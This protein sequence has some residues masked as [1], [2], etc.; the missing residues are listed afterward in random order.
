MSQALKSLVKREIISYKSYFRKED[1]T[2]YARSRF[3]N[4]VKPLT[5]EQVRRLLTLVN[6]RL[7]EIFSDLD[8]EA[9][10]TALKVLGGDEAL[11]RR[12]VK[13][14]RFNL[15][16][17]QKFQMSRKRIRKLIAKRVQEAY[18]NDVK[19]GTGKA[20]LDVAQETWERTAEFSKFIAYLVADAWNFKTLD[21]IE[22]GS[23]TGMFEIYL[24]ENH[25]HED[26]CNLYA[27]I[28]TL[29][30]DVDLPPYHPYCVCSVRDVTDPATRPSKKTTV[31]KS[32]LTPAQKNA[33]KLQAL[34]NEY[35][36]WYGHTFDFSGMDYGVAKE[37]AEHYD[38]L[39][40]EYPNTAARLRYIGTYQNK[41]KDDYGHRLD[42][43]TIA[44]AT[45]DGK[46]IA[47]NHRYFSDRA[48]IEGAKTESLQSNWSVQDGSITTSLTHEFGH[49]LDNYAQHLPESIPV[50]DYTM[51]SGVGEYWHIRSLHY[52]IYENAPEDDSLSRY[53]RTRSRWNINY[54]FAE[55]RAESI[56][57]AWHRSEDKRTEFD[58]AVE[59]F[60]TASEEW[61]PEWVDREDY[62]YFEDAEDKDEAIKSIVATYKDFGLDIAIDAEKKVYV[63]RNGLI[64]LMTEGGEIDRLVYAPNY[65]S[66][67]S[68]QHILDLFD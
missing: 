57:A 16:F 11:M 43:D 23:Q 32:I 54:P 6:A 8:A 30:D 42:T 34:E 28:Y 50:A 17:S 67:S 18:S 49:Q 66:Q 21:K 35:E 13:R 56:S 51:E 15:T 22:D 2:S 68:F 48:T 47:F 53:A 46:R 41:D 39:A 52:S 27:G 61:T 12:F 9:R 1:I 62:E 38:S 26:I 63:R 14:D 36:E 45:A 20:L 58:L 24:S 10:K 3:P 37:I 31:S 44:H 5:R 19:S 59:K 7:N 60:L 4:K 25:E 40:A 33:E 29:D 64:Y 65:G 55:A